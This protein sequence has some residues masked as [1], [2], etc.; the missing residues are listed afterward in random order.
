MGKKTGVKRTILPPRRSTAEFQ[1]PSISVT[2]KRTSSKINLVPIAEEISFTSCSKE[3]IDLARQLANTYKLTE[4]VSSQASTQS[5]NSSGS[6][7][8][9]SKAKPRA[10]KVAING[11]VSN[12]T[13]HLVCGDSSEVK[14]L[15]QDS[16]N[17]Q[18]SQCPKVRRTVNLL[19]G[20]L[21]GCWI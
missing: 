15:S 5:S 21:H 3:D 12:E 11:K 13:T 1:S 18:K 6:R 8:A 17:S 7:I 20:I 9:H 14:A 4:K 2:G 19:K 10:I 16:S